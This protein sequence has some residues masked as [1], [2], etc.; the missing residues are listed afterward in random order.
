MRA[1][2]TVITL[3]LALTVAAPGVS[4]ASGHAR[5]QA[6]TIRMG[7]FF[8][9]PARI[10]VHVGQQVRFVNVGRITHTVSD[11]DAKWNVRSKL[12]EPRPLAH[13]RSQTVTFARPGL[14]RYLCT[15]HPTLMRG[16]ITVVR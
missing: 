4:T 1:L 6:V 11:T 14:V 8:Y 13:G 12:I 15:F 3:S 2:A 5:H 16:T 10:T 9:R 7:E